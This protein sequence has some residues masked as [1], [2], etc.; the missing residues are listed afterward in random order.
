MADCECITGCPFFNDQ[1]QGM[2]SIKE[3]MKKRY[4]KG[5]NS[6]CARYKVF[7]VLGRAKVPANLIPNQLD[8]ADKIIAGA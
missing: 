7:K 4:C 2:D 1:M 5:D 3:L 6:G 8:R